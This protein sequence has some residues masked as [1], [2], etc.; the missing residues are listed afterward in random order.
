VHGTGGVGCWAWR[1]AA[2]GRFQVRRDTG[3]DAGRSRYPVRRLARHVPSWRQ[4]QE[5]RRSGL[6][7]R[8]AAAH[9]ASHIIL[10]QRLLARE[11]EIVHRDATG[12]PACMGRVLAA[13][14]AFVTQC[15]GRI[16]RPRCFTDAVSLALKHCSSCSMLA[17][18]TAIITRNDRTEDP[19]W[20]G[21]T[22]GEGRRDAAHCV[23]RRSY[24]APQPVPPSGPRR[25]TPT[26]DSTPSSSTDH[27]I[28]HSGRDFPQP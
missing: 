22:V 25:R 2:R 9:E 4:E 11:P 8:A 19:G 12:W 21:T 16:P 28:S 15:P 6:T 7:D 1:W 3:D 26:R 14:G 17:V 27:V 13:G 18:S 10:R 5:A 24:G 20:L 23:L